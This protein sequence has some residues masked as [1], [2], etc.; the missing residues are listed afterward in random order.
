MR[1]RIA[2][3]MQCL[4]VLASL[5]AA[6]A[7][8]AQTAEWPTRPVRVL[9]IASAGGPTD[10]VARLISDGLSKRMP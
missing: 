9:V 4:C 6:P 2:Y 7:V 10:L 1:L 8:W 3:A 5:G